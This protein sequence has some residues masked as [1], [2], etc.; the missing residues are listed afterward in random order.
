MR[1][2]RRAWLE[3]LLQDARYG[4]RRLAREPRFAATAILILAIGIGA[5]TAMYT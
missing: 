5:C 1:G 4:L 3:A 2:L